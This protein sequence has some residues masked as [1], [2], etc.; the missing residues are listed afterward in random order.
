[1]TEG[2]SAGV[3]FSLL[4][5]VLAVSS[6]AGRRI[7]LSFAIKSALAWAAIIGIIYIVV[8][9]LPAIFASFQ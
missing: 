1:M 5:L 2:Q 7:P 6:L 8:V 9:N 4:C 3:I